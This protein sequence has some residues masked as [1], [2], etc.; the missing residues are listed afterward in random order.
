MRNFAPK[1]SADLFAVLADRARL[2]I[3]FL[4][5]DGERTVS[6]L[7]AHT[8]LSPATV[9]HHLRVLRLYRLVRARRAHRQLFYHLAADGAMATAA[10][11]SLL[12][13]A[14]GSW[15]VRVAPRPAAARPHVVT[16]AIP[17]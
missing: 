6:D 10:D 1:T 15:Q 9:S 7:I 12:L 8:G 17:A 2:S 4:L 11:G 14:V 16:A 5:T 13:R 3:L